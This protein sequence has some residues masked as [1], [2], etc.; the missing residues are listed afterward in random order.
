[1]KNENHEMREIM[2]QYIY[3]R[4]IELATKA[5]DTGKFTPEQIA[6]V[7]QLPIHVVEDLASKKSA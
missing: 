2:E 7:L 4:T 1:M 3:E 6:T 5:I